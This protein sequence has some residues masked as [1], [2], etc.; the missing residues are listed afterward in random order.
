VPAVRRCGAQ[1]HGDRFDMIM[2][3]EGIVIRLADLKKNKLSALFFNFLFNLNKVL[4]YESRDPGI[5]FQERSTPNLTLARGGGG[6]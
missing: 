6:T 3:K 4:L 2:P 5:I 1:G